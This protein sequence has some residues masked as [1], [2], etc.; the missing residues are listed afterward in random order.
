MDLHMPVMD[1]YTATECIRQWEA[2]NKRQ[3][4]PIIAL[5]ADAFEE[6]RQ[7]CMAVGMDDFLTKPIAIETLKIALTKWLSAPMESSG[8]RL[9][10]LEPFKPVDLSA[11]IALVSDI[12]PLLETHKFDVFTH[13]Q[14]LKI[15]VSGTEMEQEIDEIEVE[16]KL[17]HFDFVLER[18]RQLVIDQIER[19]QK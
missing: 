16:L 9:V 18:L 5:T 10:S 3:R 12:S 17:F 2:L 11:F 19:I 7:R 8:P 13:F 15:L 4:I 1:G 6:D 14:S